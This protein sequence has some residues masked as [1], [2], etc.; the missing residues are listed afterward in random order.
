M[1]NTVEITELDM[2]I[3]TVFNMSDA[4]RLAREE[5]QFKIQNAGQGIRFNTPKLDEYLIPPTTGDLVI[6]CGRPHNFKSGI[7]RHVFYGELQAII[8]RKNYTE[9]GIF[10]SREETVERAAMYWLAVKSGVSVTEMRKGA[11]TKHDVKNIDVAIVQV[12]DWPMFFIGHSTKR[13]A[14]GKRKRPKLTPKTLDKALG[15]IINTMKF[16]PTI[17]C[18][19]YL[20]RLQSDLPS[21]NKLEHYS[22]CVDWAKD[23]A[24]WTGSAAY[25]GSQAGRQ[26]QD[27]AFAMPALEDSQWSSNA[28]QSADQFYGVWM[29]KTKYPP[30]QEVQSVT[31]EG[32]EVDITDRMLLLQVHKQKDG[33][34]GRVFPLHIEPE[35]LK[36]H[37]MEIPEW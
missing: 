23:M 35:Y 18:V 5:I 16:D 29:P 20:Q 24:L 9:C 14:N 19:D 25:L 34:A 21:K 33:E 6:V 30:S 11:I 17:V 1:R 28:E 12:L 13:S 15:Y 36:I 7:L 32:K 22:D 26:V 31:I 27:R 4:T 37:D 8:A 2:G 10:I 3:D